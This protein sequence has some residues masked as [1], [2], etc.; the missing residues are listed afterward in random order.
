[1]VGKTAAPMPENENPDATPTGNPT[2]VPMAAEKMI[3]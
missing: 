3:F 1:M 2:R